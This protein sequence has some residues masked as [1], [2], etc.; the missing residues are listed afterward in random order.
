MNR[1]SHDKIV[2]HEE[3]SYST[4]IHEAGHAFAAWHFGL[5]DIVVTFG[6][7]ELAAEG[8]AACVAFNRVD[9]PASITREDLTIYAKQDR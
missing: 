9:L 5:S 3:S 7:A 8:A 6:G 4:Y 2:K 1:F